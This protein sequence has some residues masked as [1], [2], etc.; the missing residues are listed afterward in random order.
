MEDTI[1]QKENETSSKVKKY[2]VFA[3]L[4]FAVAALV[5][6]IYYYQQVTKPTTDSE[7]RVGSVLSRPKE[8]YG[9]QVTL[10]GD[11]GK[12]VGQQSFTINSPNFLQGDL[13][14]ISKESLGPIGG[15]GESGISEEERVLIT[16][17]VREFRIREI[18]KEL[19]EDLVDNTFADWEGKPVVLAENVE[20][21]K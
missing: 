7:R 5:F 9:E 12:T 19:G 21:E 3:V 20:I 14:V 6:G 10:T 11:I 13:L 17:I 1:K 16:G 18:E 15:S 2:L 4:V 8:F